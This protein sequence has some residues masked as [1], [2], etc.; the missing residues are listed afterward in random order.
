MQFGSEYLKNKYNIPGTQIRTSYLGV[1]DYGI[2]NHPSED[3]VFR[4]VSCSGI[5]LLKRLNLIVLGIREITKLKPEKKIEWIHFGDG[6]LRNEI[7]KLIDEI[8]NKKVSLELKGQVA[9]SQIIEHY[10]NK[11]VDVF[12]NVSTYEGQPVS[13]KEAISFGIPI[14]ATDVGGNSEIVS[15][16]NGILLSANP[17]SLEIARSIC[18]LME[19]NE[20]YKEMRTNSRRLFL[21]KYDSK[22]VYPDFILKMKNVVNNTL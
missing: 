18:C 13:I 3:G 10:K 6:D 2:I 5:I 22:I 16:E 11:P 1:D 19:N 4:I 9:L 21:E 20:K 17:T 7:E 14:I 8:I 12:I 15:K